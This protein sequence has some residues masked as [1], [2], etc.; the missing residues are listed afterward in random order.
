M[1]LFL[2]SSAKL[3]T[4]YSYIGIALR[5][6]LRLGLHRSV[7]ANFNPIERELRRRIFWVIRKMDVY[8]STLL[9][10]PQMLSDEDIDQQYPMAIDSE[11]IS[12]DG[13]TP[14]PSDR[15]PLIA[16]AN[17]H[18][19]LS[20][21]M[22]KV[23]RYIY[24]VKHAKRS[25]T[26]Q[27]YMVSHAKIRDI[28]R[29][30]QNWMEDLPSALRPGTEVSPQLERCVAWVLDSFHSNRSRIR[31]LLRISYAHT[32]MVMYRPFLHYVSSGSQ[33]RGVDKRSYACAAAC[34][35]VARNIVHITTGMHK[36]GLL[37]GSYWFTM[38]TTYF[39]ILSLIFFV[40]EN[41]DS[42]TAKDGVLK[43]A[44]EGKNTLAGL[45]KRSLA[46]DR[47]SQSLVVC[48]AIHF[49]ILANFFQSVFRNLPEMLKNRQSSKAPANLKRP[50][51]SNKPRDT[52]DTKG[53]EAV[54]RLSPPQRANSFPIQRSP[55]GD[56]DTALGA[57]DKQATQTRGTWAAPT[58][59]FMTETIPTPTETLGANQPSGLGAAPS[60][61]TSLAN[62]DPSVL[63][64]SLLN[65]GN[66]P[67]LM[68]IMFPSD[69]PFAYPTQPMSALENGHFRQD[70]ASQQAFTFNRTQQSAM[71]STTGDRSQATMGMP[72]ATFDNWNNFSGM[73]NGLSAMNA[74]QFG[75]QFSQSGLQP[76]IPNAV[77]NSSSG[78]S[79]PDL[80]SL[81]NQNFAWQ[82]YSTRPQTMPTA[83][84]Q[85]IPAMDDRQNFGMNWDS[86]SLGAGLDLGIPL[87]DILGNDAGRPT[88]N[89]TN[90]DWMQWMNVS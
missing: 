27:H 28:E 83:Q 1:V 22:M 34:V 75:N 85:Q 36:R 77:P 82:N 13:I 78:L 72:T 24:P 54:P 32:Q 53:A 70:G 33:A 60:L 73:A 3:S 2:Q 35:S 68:P 61:P 18:T 26:D 74:N 15:T 65:L 55:T 64:Q 37:N 6:A 23:V 59:D 76:S 19:A 50:A 58:P 57:G 31:Q 4:C 14:M 90:D 25:I 49:D 30:L 40:L 38:Y 86:T 44:M 56:S 46:A 42:P 39:A 8:V 84:S 48:V 47:C 88:G 7:T 29:D 12:V 80:V 43:D 41:P 51:S 17:A 11:F 10:L 16:G 62:Q 20:N 9:G 5:S 52:K 67:D 71:P 45:A 69:D 79:S 87:D 21:I 89:L 66:V 81:P 63:Q